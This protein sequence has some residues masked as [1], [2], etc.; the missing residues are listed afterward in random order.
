MRA[1]KDIPATIEDARKYHNILLQAAM[2]LAAF[3]SQHISSPSS[4][5][6]RGDVGGNTRKRLT[7][8][9]IQLD[10]GS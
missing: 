9:R 4:L 7:F 8:E 2:G 5:F 10:G 3:E 1:F 6:V